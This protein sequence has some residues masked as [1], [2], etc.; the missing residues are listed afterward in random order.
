MYY[1]YFIAIFLYIISIL[2]NQKKYKYVYFL[3][4]FITLDIFASLRGYTIG[5]DL[6]YYLPLFNDISKMSFE[7]LTSSYDKYGFIFKFYFWI[8]SFISN[9][10]SFFLFCGST[11]TLYVV[12]KFFYNNSKDIG[13]S[14]LLY[15]AFGYYTNTFNSVRAMMALAISTIGVQYILRNKRFLAFLFFLIAFEIH[16]TIFPIFLLIFINHYQLTFKKI[17]VLIAI[18]FFLSSAI[19]ISGLANIILLYDQSYAMA[20][21]FSGGG[22][23]LLAV[24]TAIT[25]FSFY[26]FR[27]SKDYKNQLFLK[28]MLCATC[29]QTL[30]PVFSYATRISYFF[31][32][33]QTLLLPNLLK[34]YF[35]GPTHKIVISAFLFITLVYMKI[36]LMTPI[37]TTGYKTNSQGTIPYYYFWQNRPNL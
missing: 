11:L 28:L 3:I 34:T 16:K 8:C 35:K 31:A 1:Y 25:L 4:C 6:A 10:P 22:Y 15:I 12:L 32:F 17:I 18:S 26:F 37:E 9:H 5:G 23:V 36:T 7:Q 29:L 14:V 27:N 24:Y 19:G 20:D 13:L 33:Y 21:D 2:L 30:A